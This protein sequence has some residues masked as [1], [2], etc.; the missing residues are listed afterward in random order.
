MLIV[1]AYKINELRAMSE[2]LED[3]TIIINLENGSYYNMN[4]TGTIIW[5]KI[6]S[7]YSNLQIIEYFINN[8]NETYE[9]IEDSVIKLIEFLKNDNLILEVEYNEP[10][11]PEYG[12]FT[13]EN[14]VIPLIERY[15]DM[16]EMLL[17][18]PIHDVQ[19]EGW[20]MIKSKVN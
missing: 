11:K 4:K 7:N 19:E 8:F 16:Q 10:V 18:D 12:K 20:P 13:K 14:F 3:E 15:D 6:Q 17:A 2:T 9:I 1:K 5:D